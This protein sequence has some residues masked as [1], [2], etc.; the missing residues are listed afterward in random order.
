MTSIEG[1]HVNTEE[2]CK[3]FLNKEIPWI[4]SADEEYLGAGMYFWDNKANAK[5]WYNERRRKHPHN[6][7]MAVSCNFSLER[8]LDLTDEDILCVV[9][10]TWNAIEKLGK[11][12][13]LP[14][15]TGARLDYIRKYNA[16]I[17]TLT[18]F[19][20]IA[21]YTKNEPKYAIWNSFMAYNVKT[22]YCVK[23]PEALI[24]EP[25]DCTKEVV[26]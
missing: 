16:L 14:T 6:S 21:K 8:L 20:M 22:I 7:F 23:D 11:R 18:V 15:K 12:Q 9:N 13:N 25:V 10:K 19:K 2:K 24:G 17:S 1:Y 3:Q 5:Y 26:A 4:V